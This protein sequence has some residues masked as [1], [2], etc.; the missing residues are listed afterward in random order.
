MIA[1]WEVDRYRSAG[2]ICDHEGTGDGDVE[3]DRD[4]VRGELGRVVEGVG[5]VAEVLGD[6][7]SLTPCADPQAMANAARILLQDAE[8]HRRTSLAGRQR[9]IRLFEQR[10]VVQL[11]LD[12]Y[13]K[14]LERD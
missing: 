7:G 2:F 1:D 10:D 8:L 14:T 13:I 11:Y 6:T 3:L 12:L 4:R 5:G 9:A